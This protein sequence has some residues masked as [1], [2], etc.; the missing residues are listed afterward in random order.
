MIAHQKM[1]FRKVATTMTTT[2]TVRVETTQYQGAHGRL[3]RGRGLWFFAFDRGG[4]AASKVAA[5]IFSSVAA[6]QMQSM[7]ARWWKAMRAWAS[8]AWNARC[9]PEAHRL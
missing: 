2:T 6:R 9:A 7:S 1:M 5:S 3:P 4:E 8:R